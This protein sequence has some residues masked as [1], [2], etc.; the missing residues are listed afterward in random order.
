M[1][2][3]QSPTRDAHGSVL[4]EETRAGR[5]QVAVHAAGAAF[6]A[7][8][9][10]AFGGLGSGPDPYDLMGAALGACTAMT[11]RLYA[12]R[13]A[14]PLSRVA[15]QVSH[16]RA[17]LEARDRFDR[18]IM[19]EGALDAVQTARLLDIASRCPVHVTLERGAD[20]TTLL[21]ESRLGEEALVSGSAG[22]HMRHMSEASTAE[23]DPA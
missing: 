11:L 17:T 14:W 3:P 20:V 4:I 13:K 12:H 16:V 9:P 7:D 15:V 21:V 10:V 23:D 22:Q 18:K 6:F 1:S 19:L 2:E 5:Y 8:E